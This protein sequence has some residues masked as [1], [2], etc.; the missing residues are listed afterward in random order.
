MDA[1]EVMKYKGV[2]EMLLDIFS[3]FEINI[4]ARGC[5]VLGGL[6]LPIGREG[7]NLGAQADRGRV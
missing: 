4:Y 2:S 7:D 6:T 3:I 5:G 1:V